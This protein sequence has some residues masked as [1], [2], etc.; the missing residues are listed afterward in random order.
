MLLMIKYRAEGTCGRGNKTQE[1]K[2]IHY[3]LSI[4]IILSNIITN[5]SRQFL[6]H[7]KNAICSLLCAVLLQNVRTK[8]GNTVVLGDRSFQIFFSTI[9]NHNS[10]MN[11]RN[12]VFN[13]QD[14]VKEYKILFRPS[15]DIS[16]FQCDWFLK[17]VS[18]LDFLTMKISLK[19]FQQSKKLEVEA[20]LA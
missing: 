7:E 10:L 9:H 19:R 1:A 4:I 2:I 5:N 13:I 18:E 14:I 16:R 6:Q 15:S 8:G 12:A 11:F 20:R 3:H 17:L